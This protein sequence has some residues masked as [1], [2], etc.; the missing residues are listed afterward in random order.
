MLGFVGG[1]LDRLEVR[2]LVRE[3]DRTGIVGLVEV[4]VGIVV[5]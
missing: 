2:E 1:Q 5:I 3:G 4:K